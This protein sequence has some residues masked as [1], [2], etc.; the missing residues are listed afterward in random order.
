MLGFVAVLV[1]SIFLSRQYVGHS[2]VTD[3]SV[4][5]GVILALVVIH[6]AQRRR[7]VWRLLRALTGVAS[8][9]TAQL[10]LALSDS[11]LFLLLLNAMGSGLADFLTGRTIMLSGLPGRLGK[12]HLDS[13]LVL[14]VYVIVHAVRRRGRLRTSHVR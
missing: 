9:S 3:H 10:R 1:S 5:G 7:S 8:T 4:I 6:L 13:A 2:G 14:V 12:W 11:V